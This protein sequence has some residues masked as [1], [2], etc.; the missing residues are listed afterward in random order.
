VGAWGGV[1]DA[2]D[3]DASGAS[4][5]L[6]P[7]APNSKLTH[8]PNLRADETTRLNHIAE[9]LY[10][11]FQHLLAWRQKLLIVFPAANCASIKKKLR[12]FVTRQEGRTCAVISDWSYGYPLLSPAPHGGSAQ[13]ADAEPAQDCTCRLRHYFGHK[14]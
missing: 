4:A 8:Y 10:E 7:Q 13:A 6:L 1:F 9:F 2:P 3:S 5:S 14:D 11:R 12:T